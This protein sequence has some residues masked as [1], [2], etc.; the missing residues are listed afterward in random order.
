M[1]YEKIKNIF[2]KNQIR[3][4]N[5][6]LVPSISFDGFVRDELM[7]VKVSSDDSC[8][9]WRPMDGNVYHLSSDQIKKF[10]CVGSCSC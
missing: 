4:D 10:K 5:T 1:T 6:Y 3:K 7:Y 8:T 2:E 9:V